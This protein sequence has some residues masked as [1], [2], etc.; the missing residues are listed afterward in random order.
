MWAALAALEDTDGLQQ[1]VAFNNSEIKFVQESLDDIPGLNIF[2]SRGN[3][4]LF[5]GGPAGKSGA[6]MVAY[7]Q[8]KG[9]IFRPQSKM[10]GSDGFFRLTL[11]SDAENRIAVET[12]REFFLQ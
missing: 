10:Y 3:Y 2:Y 6:D 11:G 8:E 12:I 9:L 1:R 4:I 5:D 7:A